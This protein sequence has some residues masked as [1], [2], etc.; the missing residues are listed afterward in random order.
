METAS[1]SPIVLDSDTLM[2]HA[3]RLRANEPQW[4]IYQTLFADSPGRFS[5]IS[6]LHQNGPEDR[7]HI[8]VGC[9]TK[10]YNCTF[11][12]YGYLKNGFQ[13][14]EITQSTPDGPKTVATFNPPTK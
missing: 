11:H 3:F 8:S 1:P 10:H 5:V 2:K 12:I 7:L 6:E 14:T 4:I 9:K 13:F